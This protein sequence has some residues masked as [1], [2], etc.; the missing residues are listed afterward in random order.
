MRKNKN[1]MCQ[2][3]ILDDLLEL[4]DESYRIFQA[5]LMLEID[6][7]KII[8]IRTPVLRKYAKNIAKTEEATKFLENVPHR[9][10]E[11]NN[12]HAELL[13]LVYAGDIEK[14]LE[15]LER[16]LPYVDNWA[17]CDMLAS[18]VSKKYLPYMYDKVLKWL[19]C[20]H[21]YTVRFGI[22]ILLKFYLEDAFKSEMLAL[23]AD[24][25]SEEYYVKMAIAW[26]FS[27]ALIKQYDETIVYMQKQML[28]PWTHNKAIQKAIESRQISLEK[29]EYL[30]GLKYHFKE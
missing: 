14:F 13:P 24:V 26:Y 25:K 3:I 8:G 29:K 27:I 19:Q 20:D 5:K 2:R 9:F 23:V 6:S 16:F 30:R 4:K 22:V 7:D 15:E 11:E 1:R 21:T 18:K 10:Y 17:T 28:E 12:L